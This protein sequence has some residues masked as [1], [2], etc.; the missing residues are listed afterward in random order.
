MSTSIQKIPVHR[1][2]G[3]PTTLGEYDGKVLLVVNV[4]SKC[5]LTPQYEGLEKL[6]KTYRDHGLVVSGFPANDFKSQEPG[7]NEEIQNFCRTNYGVDFPMFEKITVVGEGKHPLYKELIAA[8][9][10]AVSTSEVPF[11]EDLKKYGIDPNPEPEILWNFE[12]FV[13]SRDG[14]V[15]ARFAPNTTPE[16]PALI[17]TI[18]AELAKA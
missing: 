5:G 14:K 7:S 2:T 12:K 17:K 6:Y 10:K 11:G 15:A 4:A 13:I 3:E 8:K 16:D 18:E 9:P 1:I